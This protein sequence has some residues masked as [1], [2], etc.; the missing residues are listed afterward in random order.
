MDELQKQNY[1]L[2]FH[3][4]PNM[5]EAK[6]KEIKQ[7]IEELIAS[8][9]GMISFSKEPEKIHLSY[10]VKRHQYA[11]F[12]YVQFGT[13]SRIIFDTVNAQLKLNPEIIRYFILKLESDSEKRNTM[14]K[15]AKAQEKKAKAKVSAEAKEAK[16]EPRGEQGEKKL[17]EQLE[18]II[19]K[20]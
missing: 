14:M 9:G 19:G 5:E 18:D 3:I 4:S 6:A 2:A 8:N 13:T 15:R 12:G 11:Y 16:K 7:S 17:E 10:P 20:L 1:E